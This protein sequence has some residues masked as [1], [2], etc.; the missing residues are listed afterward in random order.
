MLQTRNKTFVVWCVYI[1]SCLTSGETA[2]QRFT[3]KES[4]I[5]DI[6]P[7]S[8]GRM[9]KKDFDFKPLNIISTFTLY[10]NTM[11]LEIPT[12][13]FFVFPKKLFLLNFIKPRDR[14][15]DVKESKRFMRKK[16]EAYS[17]QIIKSFTSITFIYMNK[18]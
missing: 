17:R 5:S 16:S 4:V 1:I 2:F 14:Y 11:K 13:C 10:Y 8:F 3:F 12:Q 18:K 15:L 9:W 6:I 7:V